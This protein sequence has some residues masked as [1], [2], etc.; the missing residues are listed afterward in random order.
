MFSFSIN[1]KNVNDHACSFSSFS[2]CRELVSSDVFGGPTVGVQFSLL[3]LGAA[4]G[5]PVT[6]RF[7]IQFH[8]ILIQ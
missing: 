5:S 8:F 3:R 2:C 6:S 1:G 7:F 4:K